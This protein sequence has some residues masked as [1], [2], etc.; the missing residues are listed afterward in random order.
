VIYIPDHER[1][2]VEELVRNI[3]GRQA[4]VLGAYSSGILVF[5]P[6]DDF[7]PQPP[8]KFL[9]LNRR[10]VTYRCTTKVE[11]GGVP[12]AAFDVEVEA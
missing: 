10:P 11:L 4:K 9:L 7:G 12:D 8:L 2:K 6:V 1:E 5:L 3:A